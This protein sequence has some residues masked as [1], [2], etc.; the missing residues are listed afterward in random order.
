MSLAQDYFGD[1]SKWRDIA[2][3]NNINPLQILQ[4]GQQL[5]IPTD[6]E[7]VQRALP[8][9]TSIAGGR[10]GEAGITAILQQQATELIG[11]YLPEAQA[12]LGELN[13]ASGNVESIVQGVVSKVLGQGARSYDGSGV[14]LID[15]LL[16]PTG[17]GS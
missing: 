12:L 17:S 6:S 7:I 15:W 14:Q 5:G 8:I 13:G 9:L 11:Q 1:A 2:D 16:S 4:A 3:L 10:D